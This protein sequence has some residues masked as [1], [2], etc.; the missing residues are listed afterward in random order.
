MAASPTRLLRLTQ[1]VLAAPVATLGEDFG[2]ETD[3]TAMI[4][5]PVRAAVANAMARGRRHD[6]WQT[7]TV[8]ASVRPWRGFGEVVD[9]RHNGGPV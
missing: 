9:F 5:R 4:D 7:E 8:P 3:V 6:G 2:D 1:L